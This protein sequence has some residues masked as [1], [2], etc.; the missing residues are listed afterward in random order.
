MYASMQPHGLP[1][2]F[3]SANVVTVAFGIVVTYQHPVNIYATKSLSFY[4]PF[5]HMSTIYKV[6]LLL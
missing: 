6:L 3:L 1:T 2:F 5:L 4:L